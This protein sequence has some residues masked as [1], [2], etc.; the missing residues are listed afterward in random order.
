MKHFAI[1]AAAIAFSATS[2]FAA[3]IPGVNSISFSGDYSVASA[4]IMLGDTVTVAPTF[5]FGAGG[6]GEYVAS[7][8]VGTLSSFDLISASAPTSTNAGTMFSFG[9]Y[10]FTID[11]TE[12][13]S[14][15]NVG[16]EIFGLGTVAGGDD[17][18]G[19]PYDATASSFRF[20]IAGAESNT[21]T[22]GTFSLFISTPPEPMAPPAVPLPAGLPLLIGGLAA[23]GLARRRKS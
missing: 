3:T 13:S 9:A 14:L 19:S 10:T 22:S 8:G 15:D 6:I 18:T 17:G 1:T 5:S 21:A 2:A 4:P 20:T 11:S 16:L 7:E 12:T 23:L